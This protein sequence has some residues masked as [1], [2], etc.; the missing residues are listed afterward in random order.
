MSWLRKYELLLKEYLISKDIN[1]ITGWNYTLTRKWRIEFL[2]KLKSNGIELSNQNKIPTELFLEEIGKD[3]EYFE[4]KMEQE[5][6]LVET[7][8]KTHKLMENK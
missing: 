7:K 1:E 5:Y 4:E 8:S 3:I 2:A 6:K